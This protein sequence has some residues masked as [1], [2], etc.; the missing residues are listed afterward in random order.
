MSQQY[1]LILPIKEKQNNSTHINIDYGAKST[2]GLRKENKK[3]TT[4][5]SYN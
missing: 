5:L 4:Q 1:L 2:K 3:K